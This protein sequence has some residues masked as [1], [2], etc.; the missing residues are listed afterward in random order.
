M[1]GDIPQ[2]A[3]RLLTAL[4]VRTHF[5][6]PEPE[7]QYHRSRRMPEGQSRAVEIQGVAFES[8]AKAQKHLRIGKRRLLKMIE[9]GGGRFVGGEDGIS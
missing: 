2:V 7:R 6:P 9:A 8:L 4:P 1:R 3:F 5:Q